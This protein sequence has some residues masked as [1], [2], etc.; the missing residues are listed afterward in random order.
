MAMAHAYAVKNGLYQPLSG[1]E[2]Q[3]SM[4]FAARAGRPAPPPMVP[5]SAPDSTSAAFNP[6]AKDVKL[7]DLRAMAIRQ[8]LEG[9]DS[10]LSYR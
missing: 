4:G 5:S 2:I 10:S 3:D 9:K 6:W 7:E 1:E 8:Q